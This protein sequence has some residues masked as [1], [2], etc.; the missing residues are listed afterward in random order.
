MKTF[1]E[2]KIDKIKGKSDEAFKGPLVSSSALNILN[3]LA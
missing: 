1:R 2:Q 3:E